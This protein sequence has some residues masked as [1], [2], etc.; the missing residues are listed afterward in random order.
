MVLKSILL[1]IIQGLTEFLPISSSGHLVIFKQ[2]M[3][4]EQPGILFEVLLHFATLI[5]IVI[6]FSKRI[7]R[8]IASIFKRW[9]LSDENFR[10]FL[11]LLLASVPAALVGIFLKRYIETLFT[12]VYLVAIML[13]ITGGVLFSSQFTPAKE[14]RKHSVVSSIIIGIAQACAILPGISRS[15]STIVA[16]LWSGLKK[17]AAMEFSFILAIP[18]MLGAMVMQIGEVGDAVHQGM[19]GIFLLGAL[20][21]F[22]T[23]FIALVVLIRIVKRGQLHH[24]AYYCWIVGAASMV[25]KIFFLK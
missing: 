3:G 11:F 13:L 16:G 2:F 25:V 14:G 20:A 18:A 5:A 21:A 22:I 9:S 15:G 6:V 8:I 12:N 24:F 19:I 23:G 10:M 17:E 7:G 1:G 4:F